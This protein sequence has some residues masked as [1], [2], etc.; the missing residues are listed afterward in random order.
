MV[1]TLLAVMCVC[2]DICFRLYSKVCATRCHGKHVLTLHT[3]AVAFIRSLDSFESRP[4][5]IAVCHPNR[6]TNDKMGKVSSAKRSTATSTAG[7]QNV[8]RSPVQPSK[9]GKPAKRSQPRKKKGTNPFAKLSEKDPELFDFLK[10]NDDQLLDFNMETM[11]PEV[12]NDSGDE[13]EGPQSTSVSDKK[14]PKAKKPLSKKKKKKAEEINEAFNFTDEPEPKKKKRATKSTAEV[15]ESEDQKVGKDELDLNKEDDQEEQSE[16]EEDDEDDY[17]EDDEDDDDDDD[18]E[19]QAQESDQED[20][21]EEDEDDDDEE[22][23]K[24]W[25]RDVQIS[26]QM[27]IQWAEKLQNKPDKDTLKQVVLKFRSAVKCISGKSPKVR[28][29]AAVHFNSIFKMVLLDLHPA[30]MS[31][32]KLEPN[33]DEKDQSSSKLVRPKKSV[34]WKKY[35][36]LIKVYL[37]SLLEVLDTLANDEILATLLKH[38][39]NMVPFFLC[40]LPLVKRLLRQVSTIWSEGTGEQ[41]RVLS[42]L[43]ILRML[44]DQKSEMIGYILKKL[45]MS[46]VRN[47]KFTDQHNL[48]MI[49]FMRQSLVELYSLD[50]GVAYQHGFVFIRQ[51]A[52]TL[53]NSMMSNKKEG[54]KAVYNWQYIHSLLLW[55]R[56]LACLNPSDVMQPLVF[57]LVQVIFGTIK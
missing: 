11:D 48:A 29:E 16:G 55:S 56:T 43:I 25:L 42:F 32:L 23:S 19:E 53:R 26:E 14:Q 35:A 20:F 27:I 28:A 15:E 50:Q 22:N 3:H 2:V 4:H 24:R 1:A 52:I 41:S 18:D 9:S 17:D 51:C 37:I 47:C 44:R 45:Y 36:T 46:Y 40:H 49:N 38:L 13:N 31:V 39:L 12:I 10:K 5:L 8:Q 34:Y 30:L 7:R 33:A 21:E 6:P 57:P 54:F